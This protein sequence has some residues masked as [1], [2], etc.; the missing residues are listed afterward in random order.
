MTLDD[1]CQY[2]IVNGI[3]NAVVNWYKNKN[4]SDS[5]LLL[6]SNLNFQ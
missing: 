6:D 2:I 1:W 3:N 4:L 5:K